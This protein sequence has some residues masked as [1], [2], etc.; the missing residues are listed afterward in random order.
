[1]DTSQGRGM[2]TGSY[3]HFKFFDLVYTK[4]SSDAHICIW[5]GFKYGAT[6]VLSI[7]SSC[8]SAEVI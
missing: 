5:V 7:C 6:A 3:V 2:P 8:S 1:M 4:S